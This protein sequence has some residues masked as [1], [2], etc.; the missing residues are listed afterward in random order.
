M[1]M[2]L[3]VDPDSDVECDEYDLSRESLGGGFM[4]GRSG[5][6]GKQATRGSGGIK[7]SRSTLARSTCFSVSMSSHCL[8][9]SSPAN[10]ALVSDSCTGQRMAVR[11]RAICGRRLNLTGGVDFHSNDGTMRG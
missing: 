3:S 11:G 2:S 5:L 9:S 4:V 8:F 10:E 1:V 7:I 6:A